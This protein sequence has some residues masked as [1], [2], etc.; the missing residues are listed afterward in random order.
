MSKIGTVDESVLTGVK[1]LVLY[2]YIYVL[3][4]IKEKKGGKKQEKTSRKSF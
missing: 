3:K 4:E 1:G 2:I